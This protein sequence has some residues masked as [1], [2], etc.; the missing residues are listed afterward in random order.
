M[1]LES[2]SRVNTAP[3]NVHRLARLALIVLEKL[4]TE[5]G[6]QVGLVVSSLPSSKTA[7]EFNSCV[8]LLNVDPKLVS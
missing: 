2:R 3:V 6:S 8:C 7:V 1:V 4:L 5:T